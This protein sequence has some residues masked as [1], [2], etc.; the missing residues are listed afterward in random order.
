M[1]IAAGAIL[2]LF[3]REFNLLSNLPIVGGALLLLFYV[4]LRPD[5]VRRALSGRRVRYGANTVLAVLMFAA[6]GILLYWIALQNADWR[7]DL[8]EENQF[9]ALPETVELLE[10]IDGPIR[11][12]GFFTLRAAAQQEVAEARLEAMR[13]VKE[14]LTYEFVDPNANPLLAQQYELTSDGTLVFIR[15]QGE[16]RQIAKSVSLGDRDLLAALLQVTNPQE[17]RAVFVIG[18][19]GRD[20]ESFEPA[21]LGNIVSD[22]EDL[23]F[24]IDSVNLAVTGEVPPNTS[25]LLLVD[26][27]SPLN[28]SELN[29]IGD[30]LSAGGSAFIA[31]DV[32]V[33]PSRARIE[34][35]GLNGYLADTW[36]ISLRNDLIIEPE[37]GLAG[38]VVPV[39]F[40]SFD[41]GPGQ[42]AGAELDELGAIFDVARSV[43]LPNQPPGQLI[44]TPVVSTSSLAW[45]ETDLA[46][47]P[48]RDEQDHLGPVHVGVSVENPE[49]G[50]RLVLFGDTDFASNNLVYLGGNSLLFT[51]A[52]NWLARDE[53]TLELTPRQNIQRQIVIP[54]SQLMPLQVL[55]CL[56]GPSLMLL[57]GLAIWYSRRKR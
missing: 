17:K 2:I 50:A 21:G 40:I 38:Q 7:V 52:I 57:I 11:V 33:D 49:T 31:R 6:I 12:I 48:E 55:S 16:D 20:I 51:N 37:L 23:G 29:A 32:V 28:E 13:A 46:N 1:L 45:G 41:F 44:Q 42:I 53:A 43:S 27:L 54:E 30:Y 18:H 9:S 36:G 22:L 56:A 35:D 10:Q 47:Q 24:T 4:V 39:Q 3:T 8:T 15:G 14:D 5:E 19:G 34:D 25:V 26:Q